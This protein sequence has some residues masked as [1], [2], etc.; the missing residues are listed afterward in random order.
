TAL[1]YKKIQTAFS[2]LIGKSCF[3]NLPYPIEPHYFVQNPSKFFVL[4]NKPLFYYHWSVPTRLKVDDIIN[5]EYYVYSRTN[6]RY[7][8]KHRTTVY[9]YF[10]YQVY[11][12]FCYA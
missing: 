6:L 8:W 5:T 7:R 12:F 4:S 10:N 9:N 3:C 11:L 1:T 2:V